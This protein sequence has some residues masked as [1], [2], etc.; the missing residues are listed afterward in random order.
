MAFADDD[1]REMRERREIAGCADGTLRRNHWMNFGVQHRAEDFD[2]FG[3][4]AAEAFG[5]RVGAEEHHRARFGFAERS[6]DSAGVRADEIHLELSD[7]FGGDAD[8]SEL[9]EAGVDAVGGFAAGDDALD[10][11][12][13]GFHALDGVG[14]ERNL[15]AM[16]RDVIKLREREIV[17]SE[18]DCGWGRGH[19]SLRSGFETFS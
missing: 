8:G 7:L 17:A 4:D 10:D 16:E 2:G 19:A 12:A 6:A 15:C 1:V 13:R 11:G 3:S 14:S 5:E 18:L 9:A